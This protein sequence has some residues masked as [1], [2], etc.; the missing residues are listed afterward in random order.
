MIAGPLLPE[1]L[2]V[3]D[4]SNQRALI[5]AVRSMNFEVTLCTAVE[6]EDRMGQVPVPDVA[7]LCVGDIQVDRVLARL[8]RNRAGAAMPV[9]LC[10]RY[11]E[12]VVDLEDALEMGADHF[13]ETPVSADEL[14]VVLS[15]LAGE[16]VDAGGPSRAATPDVSARVEWSDAQSDVGKYADPLP[17]EP[18]PAK[19]VDARASADLDHG[20]TED[21]GAPDSL[22]PFETRPAAAAFRLEGMD[23]EMP[24]DV[25]DGAAS[26]DED[27][28]PGRPLATASAA[29]N[30]EDREARGRDVS[31]DRNARGEDTPSHEAQPRRRA[32]ASGKSGS[33]RHTCVPEILWGLY[34]ERATARLTLIRAQTTKE[35]WIERGAPIFARSSDPGDRLIELLG[36]RSLIP[37]DKLETARTLV[38]RDERRA[39]EVLVE[40][41]FLKEEELDAMLSEHLVAIVWS[42]VGWTEGDYELEHG[43]T[44]E[45]PQRIQTPI[46]PMMVEGL[47]YYTER[48]DLERWLG[49]LT[50]RTAL[51]E[52]LQAPGGFESVAASLSLGPTHAG[53]MRRLGGNETLGAMASRAHDGQGLLA[54]VYL[55][56]LEGAIKLTSVRAERRGHRSA[57][58][59]DDDRIASRL[60]LVRDGNYFALLGLRADA[61]PMEVRQAYFE[62]SRTFEPGA[63]EPG[64]RSRRADDLVELR[65]ALQEARDVLTNEVLR[66]AY[67]AHF[68]PEPER[69]PE[70]GA[71]EDA[72][73]P[74]DAGAP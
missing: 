67:L 9:I 39:G 40:A 65:A 34:R 3:G 15:Q 44:I 47:T 17:G 63:I 22:P 48:E 42:V 53:W 43:A 61:R 59:I 64:V 49:P 69:A 25:T 66:S 36:R 57:E 28:N 2:I 54:L 55:L 6:L 21:N 68:E 74:E 26:T 58:Q 27:A 41:G 46:A 60:R 70:T 37:A 8:R 14:R 50:Q 29:A 18:D 7:L 1:V 24:S 52:T 10:G 20:G 56:M 45:E 30:H 4:A 35:V 32:H 38:G 33:L 31:G 73:T 13:L 51:Q 16:P 72:A 5:G 12:G 11:G 23:D 71:S 62:L 19:V